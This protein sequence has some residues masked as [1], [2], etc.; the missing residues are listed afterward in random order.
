MP[1][2]SRSSFHR[3]RTCREKKKRSRLY[4]HEWAGGEQEAREMSRDGEEEGK[5]PRGVGMEAKENREP[6]GWLTMSKTA[7][8]RITTG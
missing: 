8:A 4:L 5:T 7:K 2:R 3:R 1:G 6:G